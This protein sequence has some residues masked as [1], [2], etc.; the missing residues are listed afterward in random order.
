MGRYHPASLKIDRGNLRT[1]LV[2]VG[3]LSADPGV[4]S[5]AAAAALTLAGASLHLWAKGCLRQDV[6][7]STAGPY[8]WVRHPFYLA[9]LLIEL[10]LCALIARG[11][12]A[13]LW[14]PLWLWIYGRTIARE[15][16][17][18][19]ELFGEPYAH[20]A[21]RVPL[22]LPLR[23]PAE[24]P[25]EAP[26]F[27]WRN[28]NLTAGREYAR[29]V[30]ILYAPLLVAVCSALL[31]SGA[32]FFLRPRGVE[33]AAALLLAAMVVAERALLRGRRERRRR[34]VPTARDVPR[35]QS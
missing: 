7:L 29:L 4:S 18:L 26:R 21:A 10:G 3:C 15:E 22:L 12:V 14:A 8:R 1:L 5:S 6:E 17:R 34:E 35:R 16:A 30:R 23:R 19:R 32:D 24:A 25:P 9:S 20:Y 2:A 13:A 11:W 31:R 28:E 33:I 27:S